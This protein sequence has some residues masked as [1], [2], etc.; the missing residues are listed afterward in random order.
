MATAEQVPET[1]DQRDTAMKTVS[2]WVWRVTLANRTR[3]F[4]VKSF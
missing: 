2:W 3:L 4:S 1:I